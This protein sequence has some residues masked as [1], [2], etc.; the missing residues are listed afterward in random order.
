ML[1]MEIAPFGT[2]EKCLV[3]DVEDAAALKIDADREFIGPAPKSQP[4]EIQSNPSSGCCLKLKI[5]VRQ[6]IQALS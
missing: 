1:T 5:S 3:R 2:V 6:P 4:A